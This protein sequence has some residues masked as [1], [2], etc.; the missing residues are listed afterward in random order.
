MNDPTPV[1]YGVE[2]G[3]ARITVNRPATLNAL[4]PAVMRG[5]R[6]ARGGRRRSRRARAVVADDILDAEVGRVASV[7]KRSSPAAVTRI[8]SSIDGAFRQS[9]SDQLDL[10]AR[11][12]A[13][14]I[15]R[16]MQE[17]ARAFVEGREPSFDG[18]R[19]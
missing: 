19:D 3:I 8:R 14:L 4:N 15:P 7:L 9:L 18:E 10:E 13:V 1:L 17:G 6:S 11:H 12:Q 5:L 16:N 2:D